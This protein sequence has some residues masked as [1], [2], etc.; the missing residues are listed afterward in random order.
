MDLRTFVRPAPQ[1]LSP[2]P[3]VGGSA[4]DSAAFRLAPPQPYIVA[5]L[6]HVGCPFAE[7]TMR[8]LG[9]V[10]LA[11]HEVAFIA[12]SHAHEPATTAWCGIVGGAGRVQL[13]TDTDR[14]LYAAWGLGLTSLGH[15]VG[16]RSLISV[17]RLATQGIHNRH[18][19]GTR[20]QQAGTFAIDQQGIV[21]WRHIP[22]HAGDLP[23]LEQATAALQEPLS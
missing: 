11:H 2:I 6:R 18:P 10:S 9:S 4:P 22:T 17:A 12:V 20:W 23:D 14:S 16:A 5:F 8:H 3:H 7:A 19:V 21:R 13:V 15:F 1:A